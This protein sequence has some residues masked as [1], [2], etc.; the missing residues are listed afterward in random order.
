MNT[1]IDWNSMSPL[2]MWRD[3]LAKSEAQWSESLSLLL[4]DP[5]AGGAVKRQVD[6]MR[7]AQRQFSEVAQASLAAINLPSRTDFEA[8]AERLGR[9][10]DGLAQVSAQLLMLREA[11]VSRGA[12]AQTS[13]ARNR[14]APAA[15]RGHAKV[16][17]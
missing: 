6:E 9:V 10:E 13:P 12:V 5:K 3:W 2:A 7:M 8:L 4:K 16:R 1:E 14:K 11:L 17:A 15:S